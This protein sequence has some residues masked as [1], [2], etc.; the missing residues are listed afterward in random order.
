MRKILVIILAMFCL[1][2]CS[3]S[4]YENLD[5]EEAY[6]AIMLDDSITVIDVRSSD[7][8]NSGHIP[9]AINI[10]LDDIDSIN[11]EKDTTIYVYCA[12]GNRS[13]EASQ[14]LVDLGYKA[15]YNIGGL[16]DYNHELE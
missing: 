5:M 10:P 11:L 4:S 12:S 14:K 16:N 9:K 8:Y 13:K 3:G 2:G 6:K 7:E 15:V 1:G